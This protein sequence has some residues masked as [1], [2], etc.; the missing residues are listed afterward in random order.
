MADE[1]TWKQATDEA[2][3]AD[4]AQADA[5]ANLRAGKAVANALRKS[6]AATDTVKLGRADYF[7]NYAG[8]F[9]SIEAHSSDGGVTA[10]G[11]YT[12]PALTAAWLDGSGATLGSGTLS[13]FVDD[14]VYL[15]HRM[16]FRVG[17]V[18]DGV[19]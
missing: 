4:K 2:N 14:S 8:R 10:N 11:G 5:F 1:A 18:G 17:A 3:A 9:I 16:L 19:E 6:L 7:Q 13:A 15:Y 12:G